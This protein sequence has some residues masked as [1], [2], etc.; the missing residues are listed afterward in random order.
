MR[1]AHWSVRSRA[2]TVAAMCVATAAA[3][4]SGTSPNQGSGGILATN[5]ANLVA[6]V[7]V[8]SSTPQA[9]VF[10]V[11]NL[12]NGTLQWSA[13][14]AKTS[15]W[16]TMQ[17]SSGEAGD[18]V[19][20][21]ANPTGLAAGIYMDTVIVTSSAGSARV[22]IELHDLASTSARSL[23]FAQQPAGVPE[24]LLQV[25]A[26]DSAENVAT[27]FT[28]L[29]TLSVIPDSGPLAGTIAVAAVAGVATFSSLGF[30]QTGCY[31]L[32][33]STPGLPPDT[34]ATFCVT[35][36]AGDT[37]AFRVQPSNAGVNKVMAPAVIVCAVDA[38]AAIDTTFAGVVFVDLGNDPG[39][40]VLT[41]AVTIKASSGCATFS[42]SLDKVG[43]GYT[44]IAHVQLVSITSNPFDIVP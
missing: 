33:A 25:V 36:G 42:L 6:S 43:S 28:G 34:S 13:R 22:A 44:L 40:A 5:P 41:G 18:S 26:R 12:G 39:G 20:V 9:M 3:C 14:F 17:P 15:A 32:I 29:V 37:L 11:L 7:T 19:V 16:L 31:R 35:L 8:G 2:M 10:H 38:S 21:W 24:Y 4:T 27:D 23:A 30:A 1:P